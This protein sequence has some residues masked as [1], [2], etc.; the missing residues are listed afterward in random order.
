MTDADSLPTERLSHRRK[1][2][3]L[4][5]VMLGLFLSALDQ[6]VV[7]VALRAITDDLHGLSRQAWVTTAYLVTGTSVGPMYGKLSDIFGRRPAYVGAISLFSAGSLLCAVAGSVAELAAFRALQGL[8]GGGLASL[9]MTVIADVTSPR[10]RGRYQGY[11]TAV[12]GTA[13]L[14]GPVV[15]GLLAGRASLLG[16][17]GWRWIF[18]LNLPL[19]SLALV[20]VL[21]LL[22]VPHRPVR[23]RLDVA[24]AVTLMAG[25]APLLVAAEQGATWGWGSLTTLSLC[26]AGLFGLAAFVAVERRA[27]D[28]ALLPLR[29]MRVQSFRLGGILHFL[30]GFTVFGATV[31]LPL[32]LQIVK[33]LTPVE[34]GLAS[35]PMAVAS[36]VA[37]LVVGRVVARTG[38]FKSCLVIGVGCL[39][40]ALPVCATLGTD[41]PAWPMITGMVLVG[42]GMGAAMQTMTTLAQSDI[43]RQ[44]MGA[45]T[46]AVNFFRSGGG[47]AGTAVSLS[48]LFSLAGS[49]IAERVSAATR[50]PAFRV[51][52][53]RPHN[54][55]SLTAL[56]APSG[57]AGPRDSAPLARLEP[58]LAR[59]FR[60]GYA[61]SMHAAFLVCSVTSLA[62]LAVAVLR[63]PDSTLPDR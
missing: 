60:E 57:D 46:A 20:V 28:A 31:I 36:L 49:R 10:E 39:S 61:A 45:G 27:G 54:A 22:H 5:G 12:F 37:T 3:V 52:A 9:A 41:T 32:Y 21:R 2:A 58:L 33:G 7:S 53:E 13:A 35:L 24:G 47:T 11:Y 26:G 23:H 14:A 38:R 59:P 6:T 4:T 19:A 62:A 8:G 42:I 56:L 15:G 43:P 30:V 63:V 16:V 17:D 34:A 25:T 50:D 44:D 1:T 40:A 51:L 18:L 55:R 29:L 48:V